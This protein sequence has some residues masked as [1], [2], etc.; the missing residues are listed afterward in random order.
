[1][2]E[3]ELTMDFHKNA[4]RQGPGS[5]FETRKALGLTGLDQDKPI[6]IADIGCGTGAQTITLA[7]NTT[8]SIIAVDLFPEFLEKLEARARE[9]HFDDRIT[10][11]ACSMDEL[12][13]DEEEFDLIW[14]EGAI[15]LMGFRKGVEQWRP[16]LKT[17]GYLVVS[18]ISW[19]THSR[20]KELEEYWRSSYPEIDMVSSKIRILEE[21]GYLPVAHFILPQYCWLDNYYR[22]M[23]EGFSEFLTEHDHSKAALAFVREHEQE[24]AMYEKY[25]D[26]FSYG[27][28]I[29]RRI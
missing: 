21:V 1:M 28:Y 8:G 22:P 26:Y 13:F 14:S 23:R 27:F 12:T 24:I 6:K 18:E 20:P 19:I 29:A 15:Y 25:K 7:E 10:T 17:G 5:A 16:F 11:M 9:L 3:Q 4:E 2:T